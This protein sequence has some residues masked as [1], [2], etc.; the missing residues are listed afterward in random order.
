[1]S[2]WPKVDRS[3][4][5]LPARLTLAQTASCTCGQ[6]APNWGLHKPQCHYRLFVEAADDLLEHEQLADLRHAAEYR[7][8]ARWRRDTGRTMVVPDATDLMVWCL[9]RDTQI[10]LGALVIGGFLGFVIGVV[11]VLVLK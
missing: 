8:I 2:R 3:E 4:N 10:G 6:K 11:L 5:S 7:A 1:M 9:K